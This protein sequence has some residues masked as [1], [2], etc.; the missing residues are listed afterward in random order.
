MHQGGDRAR[1]QR[2]EEAA[3]AV[4]APVSVVTEE[5]Q[6]SNKIDRLMLADKTEPPPRCHDNIS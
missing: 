1:A 5:D 6:S 3:R 4:R 2:L